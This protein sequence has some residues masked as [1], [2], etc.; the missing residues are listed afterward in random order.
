MERARA[1]A[2]KNHCN[3]CHTPSFAGQEN[4]PRIAGQRE[5]YLIKACAAIRKFA[6]RL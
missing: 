5:D 4:V 2:E 1:L 6:P 3:I